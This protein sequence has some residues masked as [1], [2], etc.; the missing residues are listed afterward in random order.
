LTPPWQQDGVAGISQEPIL[1]GGSHDYD[2]PVARPGTFWMH[3]HFGLQEQHLLAA[4][5]IVRDPAEAGEDVQEVIVLFHDFTFRDPAEILAELTGGGH[6]MSGMSMGGGMDHGNM[7]H[8]GMDM[9]EMNM[10]GMQIGGQM[11]G[12]A[13]LQDVQYDALLANDRT[14]DDPEVVAVEQ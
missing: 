2:F 11:A 3:S 5:L 12:M 14:L 1:D 9:G 10:G 7:D 4:P 13:H 8:G 6:G